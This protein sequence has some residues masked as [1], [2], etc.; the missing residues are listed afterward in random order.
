M[1][2]RASILHLDLDAFFA[3]VE[4]RDKPSLRGKPVV[5][6]GVGP[7]G[8]VATASYEARQ[9][10]VRSAMPGSEARRRVPH[11]AFLAGRFD[12]YH[13]SSRIVMALLA[14]YS[15]LV[16]AL[17]LDE[18]F[19]DLAA[20]GVQTDDPAE[21]TA[22]GERLRAQ[23]TERTEGLTC[24]VGIGSS[25]FMAKVASE[26]G[27]PDGL[28]LV[29]PGDEVTTIAPL[30][31]RAIPGVGPVSA[32]KLTR[33]GILTVAD[34]QRASL[35]ELNRELGPS[36]AAGLHEF[37]FAR[38]DRPVSAGREAKSISIEDTFA[39]DITDRA[40]LERIL[41]RDA[42][43]VVARLQR[44]GLFARTVQIKVRLA[45]F[46]TLTRA[47]SLVGGID[48]AATVAEIGRQLLAAIEVSGGI[49]LLGIGVSGFTQAA[50]EELFSID[51][52]QLD[53][54]QTSHQDATQGDL[55]AGP[56]GRDRREGWWPGVEVE[57]PVHGR[58][59]I[60]GSGLGRVTVR[61]ETRLRP[62]GPVKVF[63][64]DDPDLTRVTDLLPL[65]WD[66]A[67]ADEQD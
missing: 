11:A 17:S 2:D 28:H 49:R 43:R 40:E 20:G 29:R 22:L 67:A 55:G 61:F 45:D 63:S 36:W 5:I 42:G 9:F 10:G 6:G 7:R 47:R 15:P 24:S 39:Q 18:A 54:V 50:Q 32:E 4:Q 46:T 16:E 33:L 27:K 52:E 48:S 65:A 58:G 56:F 1:R 60:W 13:Q 64:Q 26:L 66:V 53:D 51:G 57:H 30:P 14:E 8:V 62:L 34:L 19:V 37:A 21:L 3:A 41:V 23:V 59:W 25:K 44:Q 12:A 35:T 38:D 31:I